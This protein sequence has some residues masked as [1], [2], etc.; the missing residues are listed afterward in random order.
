M[1][2]LLGASYYQKVYNEESL[3]KIEKENELALSTYNDKQKEEF[4]SKNGGEITE[5]RQAI[6]KVRNEKNNAVIRK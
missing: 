1:F 5:I 4:V 2:V 3:N 6:E